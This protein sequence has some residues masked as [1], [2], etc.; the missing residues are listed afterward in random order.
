[1]ATGKPRQY[2]REHLQAQERLGFEGRVRQAFR[3]S[4]AAREEFKRHLREAFP[5]LSDEKL[6]EL[7]LQRVTKWR[8]RNY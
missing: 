4:A 1:M 6:H 5:S 7:Y 3:V 2:H 8:N